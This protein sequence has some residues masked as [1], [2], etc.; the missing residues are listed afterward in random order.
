MTNPLTG[1]WSYRSFLNNPDLAVPPNDLLFGQGTITIKVADNGEIAG[2]I[3]GPGWSLDLKG[4]VTG[5][6]PLALLMTGTGQIGG[7]PWQY[8]YLGYLVPNWPNGVDQVPAIVGS[9]IR[10]IDHSGGAAKAGVV[11]SFYAVRQS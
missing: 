3:G 1:S 5:D 2:T 10:D 8:S 4:N 11:A 9:V 6:A 7:E